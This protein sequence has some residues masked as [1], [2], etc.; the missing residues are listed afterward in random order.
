MHQT[1]HC[2]NWKSVLPWPLS[3]H[4][5]HASKSP[6]QG[7]EGWG[8]L[9]FSVG[10]VITPA[11]QTSGLLLLAAEQVLRHRSPHED[12]RRDA[13]A[14]VRKPHA[15]NCPLW[16]LSVNLGL[17]AHSHVTCA[18]SEFAPTSLFERPAIRLQ[19]VWGWRLLCWIIKIKNSVLHIV[20]AELIFVEWM[21]KVL[22]KNCN[23]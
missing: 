2:G 11:T 17:G 20:G 7:W 19:S 22:E 9:P 13:R 3:N 1:H 18:C 23:S 15:G 16:L 10:C 5:E 12:E 6:T 8:Q 4:A 21:I 14:W